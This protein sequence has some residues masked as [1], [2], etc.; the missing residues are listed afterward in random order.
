[1]YFQLRWYTSHNFLIHIYY[2]HLTFPG[3]EFHPYILLWV[4]YSAFF[5]C[6]LSL[7]GD[8]YSTTSSSS[9]KFSQLQAMFKFVHV[10]SCPFPSHGSAQLCEMYYCCGSV[11][12]IFL[13]TSF[14]L[15]LWCTDQGLVKSLY[16]CFHTSRAV[17]KNPDEFLTE[18]HQMFVQ[19][20]HKLICRSV[21]WTNV[22]HLKIIYSFLLSHKCTLWNI[23]ETLFSK[24]GQQ[25]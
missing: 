24:K 13:L 4:W 23:P 10:S 3:I 12:C 5:S 18:A 15:V 21:F 1:M 22:L 9:V 19:S 11:P 17:V 14:H 20:Y 7:L 16:L 25:S 8:I 2:W 6:L